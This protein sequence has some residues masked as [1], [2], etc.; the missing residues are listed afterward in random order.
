LGAIGVVVIDFMLV[1][2]LSDPAEL[3]SAET[4][5]RWAVASVMT[6]AF[7][8]FLY[9]CRGMRRPVSGSAGTSSQRLSDLN[10]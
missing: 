9:G 8:P 6:L 4:V 2:V 5:E 10:H 1:A 7:I 3:I